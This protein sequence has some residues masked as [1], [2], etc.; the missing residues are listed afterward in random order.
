MRRYDKIISMKENKEKLPGNYIAGFV[1]GEGCFALKFRRDIQKNVGN[2]KVR[3]YFYWG[4]EFAIQLRSD[5]FK[6]LELIK[7]ALDCGSVNFLKKSGQVRYSVQN[8]KDQKEKI[9]PFFEKYSIRGK[10]G[11]DFE[12]W[13]R[14]IRILS[15]HHGDGLLNVQEGCRGFTKKEISKKDKEELEMIRNQMLVYKSRRIKPF[16][17]GGGGQRISK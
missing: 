2:Q 15:K 8:I 6:I 13:S 4:A 17:W 10:K 11:S 14:G 12:L 7:E 3:E 5:D 9:V 16:K 1:D